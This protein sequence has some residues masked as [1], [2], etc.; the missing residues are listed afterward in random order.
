MSKPLLLNARQKLLLKSVAS[1]CFVILGINGALLC[2]DPRFAVMVLLGLIMGFCGDVLLSLRAVFFYRAK[3]FLM[4]GALSFGIGHL[5]YIA[6]LLGIT[7]KA[8]W[9]GVFFLLIM[10]W[11]MLRY[12]RVRQVK[13]R[14]FFLDNR[15]YLCMVILMAGCALGTALLRPEIPALWLFFAGGLCF[16][17]SDLIFV[18]YEFGSGRKRWQSPLLLTFYYLAQLSIA[19]SLFWI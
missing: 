4:V 17:V 6:A 16:A 19:A 9:I 2:G 5:L 12:C 8:I 7:A 10:L 14:F 13:M 1:A 15:L 3:D 18:G 11:P